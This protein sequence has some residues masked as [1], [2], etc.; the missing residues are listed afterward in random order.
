MSRHQCDVTTWGSLGWC[1]DLVLV[2]RHGAGCLCS[3]LFVHC[4]GHCL[5][6]CSWT[7]FIGIYKKKKKKKKKKEKK[8]STKILKFFLWVI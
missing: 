8:K 2:S 4:S 3:A 5:G 7:L 1:R 6:N